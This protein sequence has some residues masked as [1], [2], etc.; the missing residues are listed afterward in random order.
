MGRVRRFFGGRSTKYRQ[1]DLVK[2]GDSAPYSHISAGMVGVVM[3]VYVGPDTSYD[4]EF[5]DARGG[6]LDRMVVKEVHLLDVD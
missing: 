3:G 6:V 1:N 2:L 4:V 5:L